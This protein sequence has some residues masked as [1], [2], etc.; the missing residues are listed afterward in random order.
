MKDNFSKQSKAYAHFRPH[1]PATL[2]DFF[3]THINSFDKA[4]DIATG[5]GQVAAELSKKFNQVH[6]TD[7]SAKQLAEAPALTNVFYKIEAAEESSFPD[8]YFDLITIAQAIHWFDFDKFYTNAKRMLKPH[9]VIAVIGYGLLSVNSLVDPW[10]LHFYKN[11]TGPYWDKERRYIDELYITIP[12][13]FTEITPPALKMEY[14]WTKEQFIGY[15]NTWSAVQ[16]FIKANNSHPLSA[17]LLQ[18]L[19]QLWP[20]NRLCKI[21]F[22]LLLRAGHQ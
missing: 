12:F 9:G 13:P 10:L 3:Y 18:Q 21:S 4:L 16:H 19:D 22:P 14:E 2:Y 17:G 15:L 20:D 8:K 1:Y 11:I 7:I 5:N 6:A